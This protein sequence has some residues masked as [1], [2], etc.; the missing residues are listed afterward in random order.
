MKIKITIPKTQNDK[1]TVSFGNGNRKRDSATI[2]FNAIKTYLRAYR[3]EEKI[4]I[5]INGYI[6]S[7][8]EVLNETLDSADRE[9][10]IYTT[11]CF[12]EDFLTQET[13]NKYIK[14]WEEA[15]LK[16]ERYKRTDG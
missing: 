4:A 14:R 3:K 10:L 12:L 5:V 2:I 7:H 1:W 9:H 16:I 11:S 15:R 8:L 6:D 13:L